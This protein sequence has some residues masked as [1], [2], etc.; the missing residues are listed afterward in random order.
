MN[1]FSVFQ[2][3]WRNFDYFRVPLY[4]ASIE[5]C[6]SEVGSHWW[7]AVTWTNADIIILAVKNKLKWNFSQNV[8]ISFKEIAFENVIFK[9]SFCSGTSVVKYRSLQF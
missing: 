3:F 9:M 1:W 8:N 4:E 2:V 7:Q 5:A 6:I